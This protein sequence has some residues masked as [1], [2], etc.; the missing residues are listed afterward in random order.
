MKN[1]AENSKKDP[2]AWVG[3]K[4]AS[5]IAGVSPKTLKR[6]ALA[7]VLHTKKVYTQFGFENQ[8]FLPDLEKIRAPRGVDTADGFADTPKS[9][10]TGGGQNLPATLENINAITV[11]LKEFLEIEKSKEKDRKIERRTN[12]VKI[13]C[14]L[15][16]SLMFCGFITFLAW[17]LKTTVLSPDFF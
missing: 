6:R 7:G 1:N 13:I 17:Q 8:Y 4:E 5:K 2:S 12:L 16:V 11:C 3:T 10:G 9:L 14:Y 15:V